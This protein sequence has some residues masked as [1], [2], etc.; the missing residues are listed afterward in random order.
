VPTR[1]HRLAAIG[2]LA[3]Y[4]AFAFL[5]FGL[6][7]LT[8]SGSRYLGQGTDPQIFIWAFAW[9]PHAITHAMNPFVSHAVWSPEGIDLAWT[10][11][12]P[13]LAIVFSPLTFLAGPVVSYNVAAVVMP[14]LA[15]WTAFLLC[16]HVT[17]RFWPSLAGGYLFGFSSFM[18]G[19][20]LG[21]M[22]LTPAFLLPL[23]ALVVLR[24]L[25]GGLGGRGLVLRLGP[26]LALQLLIGTELE[27]TVTLAL[28][29]SLV[30][31]YAVAPSLRGRLVASIGP[32]VG[33][34]VFAVVLTAPF[35]YYLLVGLHS[36]G[37]HHPWAYNA[38]LVNFVVPTRL[39]L[40]AA[41]WADPISRHFP[42]NVDERG[43][44]VGIPALVIV[45]LF[46]LERRRSAGGR[47]LLVAFALAVLAALGFEL[48]VN[49]NR[50]FEL[51]WGWFGRAPLFNNVLPVRLSLYVA[52]VVAVM[53]AIWAASRGGVARWLLPALAILAIVPRPAT[54]TWS[55]AYT[56]PPFFADAAYRTCLVRDENVLPLP[57][58]QDG[59]ANLWQV[60][61][62][63]RF[64]MAAGYV[65]AA[66]PASSITS[67]AVSWLVQGPPH[68]SQAVVDNMRTFL[69]SKG[70][71]SVVVDPRRR[72]GRAWLP[73]LDRI[74]TAHRI[75]GVV[76]YHLVPTPSACPGA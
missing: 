48:V 33:A 68:V 73:L 7:L 74:G 24:Y 55:Q 19:Q 6:W 22:Q 4:S 10:T 25:E 53:V 42:G 50:L 28:A 5:F 39:S 61:S 30:I 47:F 15:A 70:I 56:V 23:I 20:E 8:G 60:T 36:E 31:G 38:D 34:Y 2:A 17:E 21:H 3:V 69:G 27:F 63:F 54:N 41:G 45:A 14:A 51:P 1:R 71:T 37:F 76:W 32:L 62:D 57:A 35:V 12:V 64:R 26:L 75:G 40:A 49:G 52:L 72:R 13:A 58:I 29:C 9:W 18:V 59:D 66:P 67:P 46:A 65:A 44:Y 11:T 43:A 16:R